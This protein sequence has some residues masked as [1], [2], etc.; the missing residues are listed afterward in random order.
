MLIITALEERSV[1]SCKGSDDM[2]VSRSELSTGFTDKTHGNSKVKQR[3]S[4]ATEKAS[5]TFHDTVSANQNIKDMQD[6]G[7]IL[8]LPFIL[9][10]AFM[11]FTAFFV[12]HVQ[13]STRVLS[14]SPPIYWAAAHILASPNCSSRRW[15]YLICVYFIAYI[16]LGSLL[17]SNFYPFT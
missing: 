3:K 12:M 13:V 1:E 10:L 7:S 8:L 4:V 6:E 14:A 9:H 16:L 17:F 2:T 15:S 5:A 11:T